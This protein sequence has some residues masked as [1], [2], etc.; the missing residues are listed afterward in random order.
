M[1]FSGLFREN[2]LVNATNWVFSPAMSRM[3][4][5]SPL[6]YR[7]RPFLAVFLN[8]RYFNES[9]LFA[10]YPRIPKG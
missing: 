8:K 4:P 10:L 3:D 9:T 5:E 6:F 1:G 7:Y 2:T